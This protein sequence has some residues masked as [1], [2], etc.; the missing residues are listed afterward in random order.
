MLDSWVYLLLPFKLIF[1]NTNSNTNNAN[2]K[3]FHFS[4]YIFK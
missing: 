2:L 1:K 3:N 4:Y